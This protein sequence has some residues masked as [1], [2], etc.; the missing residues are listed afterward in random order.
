MPSP[1]NNPAG[2][3]PDNCRSCGDCSAPADRITSRSALALNVWPF[4][5]HSK[6]AEDY[7]IQRFAGHC[8]RFNRVATSAELLSAGQELGPVEQVEVAEAE[9]HDVIFPEIDLEWWMPK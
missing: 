6:G 8:T 3:T 7:G 1:R 5:I 4:V 9:L 2:P